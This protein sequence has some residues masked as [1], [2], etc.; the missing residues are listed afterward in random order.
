MM[1][2]YRIIWTISGSYAEIMLSPEAR[3]CAAA[4]IPMRIAFTVRSPAYTLV[5]LRS[6]DRLISTHNLFTTSG[7]MIKREVALELGGFQPIWGVE[8]FDLWVKATPT[9]Y[10]DMLAASHSHLSP[11]Q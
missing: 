9:P 6:P 7:S 2:G 11:A 3:R 4:L 1:S 5:V 10:C 8:D